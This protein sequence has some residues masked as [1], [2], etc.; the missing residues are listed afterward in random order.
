MNPRPARRGIWQF[1]ERPKLVKYGPFREQG[2]LD[3]RVICIGDR[4]QTISVWLR[5]GDAEYHCNV[6]DEA[7][8]RRLA[9]HAGRNE[10]QHKRTG[11]EVHSTSSRAVSI[12]IL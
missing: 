2:T 11:G 4:D 3:E 1:S 5:S 8:V 10:I 12:P 7:V 6:R 9:A